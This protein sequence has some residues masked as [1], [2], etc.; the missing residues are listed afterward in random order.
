MMLLCDSPEALDEAEKHHGQ[1]QQMTEID[2][3]DLREKIKMRADLLAVTLQTII[4][5]RQ[6]ESDKVES[7]A[8]TGGMYKNDPFRKN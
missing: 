5:V 8:R 1:L 3:E 7:S 4:Q 6:Q 2:E